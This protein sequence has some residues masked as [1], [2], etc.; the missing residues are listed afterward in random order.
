MKIVRFYMFGQVLLFL[1][2][3]SED[4]VSIDKN[5]PEEDFKYEFSKNHL[6]HDL[7]G[8]S[9]PYSFFKP[10]AAKESNE[11]YP[12]IIAL[13]GTEYYLKPESE[14]LDDTKTGY[15]ALAWIEQENQ[16][17]YPAFVVAPNLNREIWVQHSEYINGWMDDYAVDF[18]NKLLDNLIQNNQN[19]D[20]NRIY[21]TGHSMGGSATWYIGLKMKDRLAAIVSFAQAYSA[22]NTEFQWVLR[23]IGNDDFIN[24]PIWDFTH[25]RD[26]VGGAETSRIM[27]NR[28]RDKGY[29]PVYTHWLDNQGFN[30]SEEAIIDQIE[31][32][33][34]YFYTEYN[35]DCDSGEC[36]YVMTKA[37]KE[38]YLFKWLFSHK[39][40]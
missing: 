12:L 8:V 9:F 36:H 29:E 28:F 23:S 11:K 14:F 21:L 3:C 16:K 10:K 24:L 26:N 15:V 30:L 38:D 22:S 4:E 17:N 39:K 5:P 35:Y 27:F 34:Q 19:I 37:L 40:N 2:S 7:T 25:K 13:H 6:I 18:V 31:N 1:L 33:K 32:Q 20:V